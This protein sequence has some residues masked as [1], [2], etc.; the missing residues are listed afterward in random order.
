MQKTLNSCK[1]HFTQLKD[2]AR[3][4]LNQYLIADAETMA[5]TAATII[6]LPTATPDE[7]LECEE[8]AYEGSN[9]NRGPPDRNHPPPHRTVMGMF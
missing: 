5:V 9:S 6:R 2:L 3:V 4:A 7:S 1:E 8:E